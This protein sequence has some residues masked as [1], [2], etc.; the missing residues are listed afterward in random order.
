M[1]IN[2]FYM[3]LYVCFILF[4]MFFNYF[5][6]ILLS[7]PSVN[8]GSAAPGLQALNPPSASPGSAGA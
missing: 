5:S 1:M 2:D 7:P 8:P 4:Y 3:C 6:D